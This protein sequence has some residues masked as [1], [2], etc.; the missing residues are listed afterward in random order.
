MLQAQFRMCLY[1]LSRA[2]RRQSMKHSRTCHRSEIHTRAMLFDCARRP[3]LGPRAPRPARWSRSAR[4]NI[5]RRPLAGG[6]VGL[7]GREG[8]LA[9]LADGVG[10]EPTRRLPAWRFSRPLPSATRPPIRAGQDIVFSSR[11][12]TGGA[13]GCL[14]RCASARRWPRVLPKTVHRRGGRPWL[15]G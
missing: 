3:Q 5:C 9:G 12:V 6:D 2:D 8:R 15:R 1:R 10:F 7:A 4:G 11:A 13:G 14:R